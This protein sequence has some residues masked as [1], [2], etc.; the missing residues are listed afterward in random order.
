[1]IHLINRFGRSIEVTRNN[2]AVVFE[3]GY[4]VTN[5]LNETF[6]IT[7]SVQPATAEEL[8][9]LPEGSDTKEA[10]KLYTTEKLLPRQGNP[11]RKGDFFCLNGFNYEVVSVEDHA[12]HASMNIFYYKIIGFKVGYDA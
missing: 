5:N 6:T 12:S 1:M 4:A 3:D 2:T 11:P 7:A 9:Q 8:E 10:I